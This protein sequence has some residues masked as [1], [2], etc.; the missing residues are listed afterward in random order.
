MVNHYNFRKRTSGSSSSSCAK[1]FLRNG[2]VQKIPSTILN[3]GWHP[4]H[5]KDPHIALHYLK[6]APSLIPGAGTGVFA[7]RDIPAGRRVLE[8]DGQYLPYYPDLNDE[9]DDDEEEDDKKDSKDS[10]KDKNKSDCVDSCD[11][12]TDKTDKADKA[13]KK[14]RA[15][16]GH[17][18]HKYCFDVAK[19]ICLSAIISPTITKEDYKNPKKI[20][21]AGYV[22]DLDYMY[23]KKRYQTCRY[24]MKN[25][26]AWEI[27]DAKQVFLVSTCFIPKGSELG[28]KY[29]KD[30]WK[31]RR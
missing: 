26:L 5:L 18:H 8:Y 31:E 27:T 14:N 15:Y 4:C 25:N 2:R 3:A 21:M 17:D 10:K 7:G 23:N 13:D 1:T 19:N 12:K 16:H 11:V 22:N 6:L 29:G 9:T 20:S 28:V 30:Y 24:R